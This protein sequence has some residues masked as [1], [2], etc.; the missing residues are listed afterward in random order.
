MDLSMLDQILGI[1]EQ[2]SH[3]ELSARIML[4]LD[5]LDRMWNGDDKDSRTA[6]AFTASAR[7][8]YIYMQES[9]TL[10]TKKVHAALVHYMKGIHETLHEFEELGRMRCDAIEAAGVPNPLPVEEEHQLRVELDRKFHPE[11][12]DQPL[13]DD[14]AWVRAARNA[15]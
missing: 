1:Q 12:G 3:E 9:D 4:D 10:V 7:V 2:P 8:W 13:P 14:V 11:R 5:L 6:R 15:D